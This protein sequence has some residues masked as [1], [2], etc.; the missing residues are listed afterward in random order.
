MLFETNPTPTRDSDAVTTRDRSV[1]HTSMHEN[2]ETVNH[3]PVSYPWRQMA[4]AILLEND[5]TL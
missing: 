1:L 3:S 2:A 4:L 5:E